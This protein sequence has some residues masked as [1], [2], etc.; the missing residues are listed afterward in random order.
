[1]EG[2]RRR[3]VAASRRREVP[4]RR[5]SL[6][7]EGEMPSFSEGDGDDDVPSLMEEGSLV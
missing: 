4:W 2:G 7:M 3:S 5:C 6:S 1:V